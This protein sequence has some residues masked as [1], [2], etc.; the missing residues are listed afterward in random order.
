MWINATIAC[1]TGKISRGSAIFFTRARFIQI[2]R[3]PPPKVSEK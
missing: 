1:E 3:V 2:D